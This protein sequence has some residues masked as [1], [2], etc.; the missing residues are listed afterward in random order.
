LT[1]FDGHDLSG[2]QP[3]APGRPSGWTV[4]DGMLTNAANAINLVSEKKFSNFS[5]DVEFR[6]LPH[7]NSGIALRG[8]YELQ[9]FDDADK[10][11][12]NKGSGAILGR[13]APSLNAGYPA[14]EWQSLS[15]RLIGRQVTE[16]FNGIRVIDRQTI[17][18]PTAIALDANES[19]PGPILLQGDQGQVEFRKLVVYPLIKQH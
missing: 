7:S 11:P 4:K 14:G 17:D 15:V 16:I 13:I 2:W 3:E 5:M 18:G 19:E 9:L 8:R 10:P 6:I 12:S 1:L